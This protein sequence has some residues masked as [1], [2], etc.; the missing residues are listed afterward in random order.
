M[1]ANES[2]IRIGMSRAF[3]ASRLDDG[4]YGLVREF[5]WPEECTISVGGSDS[6]VIYAG[7]KQRYKKSGA[8]SKELAVQMTK[9]SR[10]FLS[11]CCGQVLEEAATGGISDTGDGTAKEFAFGMET[12]GDQGKIRTWFY[13]CTSTVPV[14]SPKTNTDQLVEAADT[15]TFTAVSVE[16]TGDG[17]E[18]LST[19]FE[20]GDAGYDTCFDAVPFQSA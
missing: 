9:F 7:D 4:K 12:T 2:K 20:V 17:V 1:A 8:A 11:A 6:Q 14:H 15:A 18:R 3:W 10:E 5:E 19:T 16:C 13:C